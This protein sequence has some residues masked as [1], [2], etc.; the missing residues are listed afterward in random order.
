MKNPVLNVLMPVYNAEKFLPESIESIL[1]QTFTDFEFIILDDG[2]TDNSFAIIKE[3]QSKD[4]RIRVLQNKKNKKLP[5]S[6]NI[7]FQETKADYIV[8][9]DADDISMPNRLQVEYDFLQ[10]N[11][12]ID[13]IGSVIGE[14]WRPKTDHKI[15]SYLLM[16][17][18]LPMPSTMIRMGKISKHF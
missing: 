7:L 13:I 1:N 8:W 3:Y 14:N 6:R 5:T 16:G 18:P 12:D 4:S 15:K 10:K 11:P 2:S 17:N 9:M